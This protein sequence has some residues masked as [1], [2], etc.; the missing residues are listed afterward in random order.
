MSSRPFGGF[1]LIGS[2]SRFDSDTCLLFVSARV[3]SGAFWP[4]L[5][6]AWAA[7]NHRDAIKNEKIKNAR[8][9]TPKVTR[10]E[11]AI[12]DIRRRSGENAR[13]TP[14]NK[15]TAAMPNSSRFAQGKSRVT[16]QLTKRNG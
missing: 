10:T 1:P 6:A 15:S 14:K 7:G 11:A 9:R 2:E 4:T 8:T 16:G 3:K 12:F 5:G 13:R